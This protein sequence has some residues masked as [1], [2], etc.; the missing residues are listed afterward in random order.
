MSEGGDCF[1]SNANYIIDRYTEFKELKDIFLCHG[2]VKGKLSS[3]G[4]VFVHCWIEIGDTFIDVSNGHEIIQRKDILY[5]S[6]RI[7][8]NS[9][10]KYTPREV[11]ELISKH[12]HYG[13]WDKSFGVNVMTLEKANKM[14]VR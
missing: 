3:A 7:F 12:K 14:I 2:Y 13:S 1:S 5:T 10:K 6:G 9:I 11:I 8:K 4:K